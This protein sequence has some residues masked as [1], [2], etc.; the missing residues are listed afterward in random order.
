MRGRGRFPDITHT[1]KQATVSC[2]VFKAF[3]FEWKNNNKSPSAQ[4]S[5][6]TSPPP[7][8]RTS[9]FAQGQKLTAASQPR[10]A[11]CVFPLFADFMSIPPRRLRERA[12]FT[13]Q[14]HVDPSPRERI[15]ALPGRVPGGS[16]VAGDGWE[17]ER[18]GHTSHLK[19]RHPSP[20]GTNPSWEL[21]CGFAPSAP[22]HS[23][24]PT[25]VNMGD[26]DG[27]RGQSETKG[28]PV[29]ADG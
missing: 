10:V 12:S 7:L 17:V 26:N 19:L 1:K 16:G 25:S 29:M 22:L 20:Q 28:A 9:A 24:V 13:R 27:N 15:P 3:L 23:A 11:L 5:T 14:G 18:R 21:T 4:P 6:S 2:L 8:T